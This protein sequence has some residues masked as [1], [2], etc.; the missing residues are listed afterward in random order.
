MTGSFALLPVTGKQDG[1]RIRP[2]DSVG[3]SVATKP[4][5]VRPG[6]FSP[7]NTNDKVMLWVGTTSK[8]VVLIAYKGFFF[9][10]GSCLNHSVR[11]PPE[12]THAMIDAIGINLE[13]LFNH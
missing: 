13:R 1:G 5:V 10:I 9:L 12:E 4:N 3:V 8:H 11:L 6:N 2:E 7:G